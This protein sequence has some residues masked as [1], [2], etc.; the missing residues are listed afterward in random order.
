MQVLNYQQI[1]PVKYWMIVNGIECHLAE[2]K[3]GNPIW[4]SSFPVFDL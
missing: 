3:A 1:L 2:K 4:V